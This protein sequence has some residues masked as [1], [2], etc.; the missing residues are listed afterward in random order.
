MLILLLIKC[1]FSGDLLDMARDTIPDL[2]LYHLRKH[3]PFWVV[4]LSDSWSRQ[5]FW[6]EFENLSFFFCAVVLM[7]FVNCFID[8]NSKK[9]KNAVI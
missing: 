6:Y 1:L 5:C 9:A 2:S 4:K 8:S 7:I 3:R